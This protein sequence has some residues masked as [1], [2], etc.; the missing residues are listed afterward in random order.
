MCKIKQV[1]QTVTTTETLKINKKN[2]K[3]YALKPGMSSLQMEWQ[4]NHDQKPS[5]KD[6]KYSIGKGL[7]LSV[8]IQLS[9][10]NIDTVK[11]VIFLDK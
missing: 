9:E 6:I 7:K 3:K 8:S 2:C 5:L 11:K 10:K 1:Y 4:A